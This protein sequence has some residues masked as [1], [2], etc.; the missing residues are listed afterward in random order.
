MLKGLLSKVPDP[1]K[2][3]SDFWKALRERKENVD[4]F[5]ET[6]V[7][8]QK[9]NPFYL[10]GPMIYFF[11]MVT[12]V[13]GFWLVLY[14]IPTSDQAYNSIVKFTHDIPFGGLI[15]GLH[16]YGADAIIIAITLRI[17]RLYF[18][19]E[20]KRPRELTWI[21]A[22]LGLI[23]AMFS[24]LTGYL[25]IWNQRAF[26]ATKVFATFPTYLDDIPIFG[27][28]NMGRNI[29]HIE[30]GGAS[31]GN[32]TIGRFYAAHFGISIIALIFVE[33]YFWR[34]GLKRINLSWTA[35]VGLLLMLAFVT[36]I[37]PTEMG[38]RSNPVVTPNPILSDW[39]FLALYQ[40]FKYMH[41]VSAVVWTTLLPAIAIVMT[42]L[43]LKKEKSPWKRPF[44]TILTIS[45]LVFFILFCALIIL[46]FADI[47]RDPPYWYASMI[48]FYTFGA[49]LQWGENALYRYLIYGAGF[50][51]LAIF[52]AIKGLLAH[53]VW[54]PSILLLALL[55]G[56][57]EFLHRFMLK[58]EGNQAA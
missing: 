32:A 3:I 22:I 55:C 25:L 24:G 20:Y 11:W 48:L 9:E 58:R 4:L 30:I 37:L 17:Y 39:Y 6:F 47:K 21:Y 51:S 13:T 44:F 27:L 5:D 57:T 28:L 7:D 18:T 52:I 29:S 14:Y 45:G 19:G 41:P 1:Q 50:I 12:F 31:I 2:L 10:A 56:M 8:R 49:L 35:Q 42:F 40:M 23:L 54:I 34:K 36:F 53:P 43:D 26:W 15:R 16:K 33:Y 38:T 46:G